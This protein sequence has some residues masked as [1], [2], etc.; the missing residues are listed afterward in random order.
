MLINKG[1]LDP[2]GHNLPVRGKTWRIK[3]NNHKISPVCA[4]WLKISVCT[5][6]AFRVSLIKILQFLICS[7]SL[8]RTVQVGS[9]Y[10]KNRDW[11]KTRFTKKKSQICK[12]RGWVENSRLIAILKHSYKGVFNNLRLISQHFVQI[13]EQWTEVI[14]SWKLWLNMCNSPYSKVFCKEGLLVM[15]VLSSRVIEL[16]HVKFEN[17]SRAVLRDSIWI[18]G[19]AA[20]KSKT[21]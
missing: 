14:L 8:F 10:C 15:F 21:K 11:N 19:T 12:L 13:C 3:N 1:L 5:C 4:A 18:L 17:C 6:S 2:P 7:L 16:L 9:H 20:S